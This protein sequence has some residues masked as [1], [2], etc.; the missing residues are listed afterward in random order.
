[1]DGATS[2]TATRSHGR[3]SSSAN[4]RTSQSASP[5][6]L[7]K[8]RD[9][10]LR[11]PLPPARAESELQ[12]AL[13]VGAFAI[14]VG[15]G[16]EFYAL[17]IAA[18]AT[19]FA[20]LMKVIQGLNRESLRPLRE[21]S[22]CI[23][24]GDYH[25]SSLSFHALRPATDLEAALQLHPT[26]EPATF[27]F[28]TQLILPVGRGRDA[29]ELVG[30]LACC[31]A[32]QTLVTIVEFTPAVRQAAPRPRALLPCLETLFLSDVTQVPYNERPWE[33]RLGRRLAARP[34]RAARSP[35]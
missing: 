27:A 17:H 30:L 3:R 34:S 20:T 19:T 9:Q 13:L 12:T 14:L 15:C 4:S 10:P 7:T 22:V 25:P 2:S 24:V 29:N 31:P 8:S 18:S 23:E 11:C 26:P 21:M 16:R 33:E 35:H 1:M 6:W 32:L 28:L 5:F